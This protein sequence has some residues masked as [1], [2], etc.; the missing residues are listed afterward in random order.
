MHY[1]L[2]ANIHS[3]SKDVYI[4]AQMVFIMHN[5]EILRYLM[6]Y[7]DISISNDIYFSP[8]RLFAVSIDTYIVRM[9]AGDELV[10]CIVL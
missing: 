1:M 6:Q 10:N 7:D 3:M 5:V 8:E 4:N 2:I 9:L